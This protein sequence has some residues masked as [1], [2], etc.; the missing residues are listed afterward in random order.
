VTIVT[1]WRRHRGAAAGRTLVFP[2][3]VLVEEA[4]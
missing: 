3:D 2:S 4:A 1:E